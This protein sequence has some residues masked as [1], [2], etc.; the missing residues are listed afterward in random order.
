MN[1]KEIAAAIKAEQP[2]AVEGLTD[3]A[4]ERLVRATLAQ[5]GKA[6]EG[7]GEGA[8]SIAGLGR[9]NVKLVDKQSD[10]GTTKVR[11]VSFKQTPEAAEAKREERRAARKA[12]AA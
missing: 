7:Q 4:V 12:A 5:V 6:V 10:A 1:S 11:K 2:K 9:F 3:T 8:L